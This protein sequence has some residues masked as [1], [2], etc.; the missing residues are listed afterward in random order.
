MKAT[1][2]IA[3]LIATMFGCGQINDAKTEKPPQVYLQTISMALGKDQIGKVEI[4]QIPPRI[5]VRA[6]VSPEALEKQYHNKL[7][8]RDIAATAYRSKVVD[9]FKTVSVQPRKDTAD[10]RWG[11]IFY[12]RDDTRVGAVYFDQSGHYGAVDN[13]PVSFQGDF[14]HWLDTTFSDCFQ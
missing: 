4:L 7:V 13:K 8:I 1:Y 6:Q 10:L 3:I 5:L 12:S 2:C 14:F 11:V 9:I